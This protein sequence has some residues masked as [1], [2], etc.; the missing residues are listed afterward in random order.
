MTLTI[1]HNPQCSKSRATLQLLKAQGKEPIIVEY[2]K[3]PPSKEE[4]IHILTLLDMTPRQL[5]RKSE[6]IYKDCS[7]ENADISDDALL[8]TIIAN[9]KLMER[10]IVLASGKACIGRPPERVLGII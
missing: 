9:P 5:L 10:P 1:Y 4:L 8:D 6:K 2:L 3:T 7:L